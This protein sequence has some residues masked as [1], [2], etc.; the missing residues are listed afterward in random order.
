MNAAWTRRLAALLIGLCLVPGLVP[1][2][3]AQSRLKEMPGYAR[4]AEVAP[5]IPGSVTSAAISPVWS[6]DSRSF[7]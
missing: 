7:T 2:G 3:M 6:S 1:A 5:Q 4:W